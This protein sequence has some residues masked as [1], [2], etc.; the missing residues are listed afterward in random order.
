[1]EHCSDVWTLSR[2]S[3]WDENMIFNVFILSCDVFLNQGPIQDRETGMEIHLT[4][5]HS[6]DIA[7][8]CNP[9][10]IFLCFFVCILFFS[11][12]L[13]KRGTKL[14][15]RKKKKR[16]YHFY[17]LFLYQ[18]L[19]ELIF[20]F[21]KKSQNLF[22]VPVAFPFTHVWSQ[23]RSQPQQQSFPRTLLSSSPRLLLLP[24]YVAPTS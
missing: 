4:E 22:P 20:F 17:L 14:L 7:L 15:G 13:W 5:D 1:M 21:K 10:T 23:L 12:R 11:E 2:A 18:G 6:D 16:H 3:V 19:L 24:L 9:C 8:A